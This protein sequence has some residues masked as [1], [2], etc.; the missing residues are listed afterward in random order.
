MESGDV[1][2]TTGPIRR[3]TLSA[4]NEATMRTVVDCG[5]SGRFVLNEPV[6]QGGTGEGPTPLQAVLGARR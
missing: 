4:R 6:S 2:K 5:E 3:R 1:S